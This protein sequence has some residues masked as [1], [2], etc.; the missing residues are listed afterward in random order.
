M[1]HASPQT[2]GV[3]LLFCLKSSFVMS[4]CWFVRSRAQ[5]YGRKLIDGFPSSACGSFSDLIYLSTHTLFGGP[6]LPWPCSIA[7]DDFFALLIFKAPPAECWNYSC[8][9]R[10]QIVQCWELTPDSPFQVLS[11]AHPA[12]HCYLL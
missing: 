2:T 1:Q 3:S 10:T 11:T 6:G 12:H 9:P 4:L 7:K 5:C 8:V